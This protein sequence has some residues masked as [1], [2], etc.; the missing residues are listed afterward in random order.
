MVFGM[1]GRGQGKKE[2]LHLEY[3]LNGEILNLKDRI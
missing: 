2:K 1:E 3:I